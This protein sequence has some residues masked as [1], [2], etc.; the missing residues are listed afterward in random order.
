MSNHVSITET[1]TTS[2]KKREIRAGVHTSVVEEWSETRGDKVV[3][4][5]VVQTM[6]SRDIAVTGENFKPNTRYYIFFDGLDVNDHMTPASTVY[7]VG[8]SAALGTG[9]RSD[10]LGKVSQFIGDNLAKLSS[11]IGENLCKSSPII[12]DNLGKL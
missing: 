8:S 6:R 7:G 2:Q 5:N 3:S 9:L 1:V 10:N 12:G 4:T 11:I